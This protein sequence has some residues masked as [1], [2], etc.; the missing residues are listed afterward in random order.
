MSVPRIYLSIPTHDR[1]NEAAI[2]I[3]MAALNAYPDYY[4]A[5]PA[6]GQ[7][8]L[9][10]SNFNQLWCNALNAR[11]KYNITHFAMLHN[12]VLPLKRDWLL[13]LLHEMVKHEADV[14]SSCVLMKSKTRRVM[15]AAWWPK[16][17]VRDDVKH[18]TEAELANMPIT[19]DSSVN[20][21][22]KLL[23]NTG[24][25]LADIRTDRLASCFFEIKNWTFPDADGVWHARDIPEDWNF[26]LQVHHRK[27]RLF[28]TQANP[29][30]H[31]GVTDWTFEGRTE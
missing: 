24:M 5:I 27:G 17:G 29:V 11:K 18:I 7:N 20:P 13:V 26:S 19:F 10:P 15:S 8:S 9:L 31:F 22:C 3:Q 4:E 21:G 6:V 16:N 23:M 25:W 14:V 28:C 30:S 12:D 2:S 1:R